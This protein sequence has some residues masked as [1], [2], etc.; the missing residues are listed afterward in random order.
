MSMPTFELL[1]SL[2]VRLV[3]VAD[4]VEGAIWLP[5]QRM[6]L[7]DANIS[8]DRAEEA[9]DAILPELWLRTG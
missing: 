1:R 3:K 8:H 4:L 9:V 5:R 6:L 7:V 2:D